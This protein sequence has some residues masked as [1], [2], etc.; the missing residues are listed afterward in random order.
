MLVVFNTHSPVL[1]IANAM[2]CG[3]RFAFSNNDDL[4][5]LAGEV[6]SEWFMG[7]KMHEFADIDPAG[8]LP[9]TADGMTRTLAGCFDAAL[10]RHLMKQ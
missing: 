3:V 9:Y 2:K 4:D 6:A 10:G 5:A 7:G 1:T 8:F